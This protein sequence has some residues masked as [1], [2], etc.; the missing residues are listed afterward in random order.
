[1]FETSLTW[2]D[3]LVPAAGRG[4]DADHHVGGARRHAARHPLRRHPRHGALVGQAPLGFVL[5]I[6]RSV[7][8]L[9]Q[10]VLANSFK[11]ILGLQVSPS[12][13]A[14]SCCRSTPRPIAPRSCAA[15]SSPCR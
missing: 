4:D 13:S 2:N 15:A 3:L 1:M 5:D 11:S 8:L 7:P 12:P 10:L 9:I 14:A 6:F